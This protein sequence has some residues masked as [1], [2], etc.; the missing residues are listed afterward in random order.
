MTYMRK[1]GCGSEAI[2]H[3]SRHFLS[4]NG[5]IWDDK[6]TNTQILFIYKIREISRQKNHKNVYYPLNPPVDHLLS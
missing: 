6:E 2:V 5:L 4:D 1:F 3:K